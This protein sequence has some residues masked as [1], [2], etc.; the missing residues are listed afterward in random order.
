MPQSVADP[1]FSQGGAPTPKSA[2]IFH[3]F[4]RKLHGNERI[5]TPPPWIR[6]C[7]LTIGIVVMLYVGEHNYI[8]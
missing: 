2:I 8:Y 3:F 4:C 5:L 7:Q 1:G 6:Q